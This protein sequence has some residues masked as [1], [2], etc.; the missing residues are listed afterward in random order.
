MANLDGAKIIKGK[1]GANVL[2][3]GDAES[4]LII[5]SP[6]AISL[7]NGEVATIYNLVDADKL[8]I[9]PA[10]D[11]ANDVH[12]YRHIREYYRIAGEGKALFI[13]LVPIATTMVA[14]VED[15]GSVYAKKLLIE[16]AGKIKQ[17]AVAMNP[18][19]A[20]TQLNGMPDDVFNAIPKA[21][22]LVDWAD[23]QFM[24]LNVVLECYDYIGNSATAQNL[25]DIANV[26]APKVSLVI[27]QDWKYADALVG[28]LQKF[29]DVGTALGTVSASR[30][31]QN[32]GDNERFNLTDAT[33]NAWL[34]P[35]L[36]SH[37][38]NKE[39]FADLQTL[40]DKGYIF[41]VSY[42]DMEGVRWNNDHT[43]VEKIVDAEGNINE[44]TIAYGRTHDKAR[45]K[46]RAV[47]L[48]K[49][50]TSR[51]VDPA[52]GLLPVG[53]IKY[54]ENLGDDVL[55]DMERRKEISAGRTIVD[56]T[57]DLLVEKLLKMKFRIVPY[58]SVD[59]IEGVSNLKTTL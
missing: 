42:V 7:V 52:T 15:V 5:A 46:L 57:S 39:A 22:G 2:D 26:A 45:R 31:N 20:T 16:G 38:T 9:N 12:A 18:A 53:V 36:S 50:K 56:P 8:G 32:I 4:G 54:F 28:N 25:R 19:G 29:A 41:G 33:K 49:V 34:V 48:P 24:S 6:A 23:N 21:Q 11:V 14:I 59:E 17:L 58:G 3:A 47:L 13:M 51:P 40:E 10:F 44:H 35:G 55:I 1:I 37:Q 27:G 30:V 43:C